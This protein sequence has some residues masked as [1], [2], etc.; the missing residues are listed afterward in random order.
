M[1]IEYLSNIYRIF[2]VHHIS[3]LICHVHGNSCRAAHQ[4]PCSFCPTAPC[5]PPPQ[6]RPAPILCH[7]QHCAGP[8]QRA[9]AWHFLSAAC[10]HVRQTVI[11]THGPAA[12]ANC[13]SKVGQV[14]RRKRISEARHL[15][16]GGGGGA[17]TEGTDRNILSAGRRALRNT[18]TRP[19]TLASARRG[20]TQ[21]V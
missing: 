16:Q 13:R 2:I 11:T 9:M 8:P 20:V 18:D 7:R 17:D 15:L 3:S 5:P 6:Q 10:V 1:F 14:P 19:L 21:E 4:Q 12:A